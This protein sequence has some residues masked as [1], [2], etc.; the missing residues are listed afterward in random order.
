MDIAIIGSGNVGKALAAAAVRNGHSVTLSAAHPEHARAAAE[1]TGALAA[2]SNLEAVER[3]EVV[4]LAVYSQ[5]IVHSST[6]SSTRSQARSW[7]IRP[8]P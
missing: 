7:S 1:S 5:V 2:E 6:R 3:A 4:V 8:T